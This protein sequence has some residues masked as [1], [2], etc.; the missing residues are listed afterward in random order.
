MKKFLMT[1]MFALLSF[2]AFCASSPMRVVEP[3]CE[4]LKNPIC[5]DIQNPRFSWM[6]QDS[7]KNAAQSAYRILVGMDSS[8]LIDGKADSVI[9]HP[10]LGIVIGSNLFASFTSPDLKFP[11]RRAFIIF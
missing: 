4:Y 2:A 5:I 10:V 7:R 3:K 1:G 11:F 6:L 8:A 9:S